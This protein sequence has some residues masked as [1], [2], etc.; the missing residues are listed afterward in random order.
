[1]VEAAGDH[2]IAMALAVAA[3]LAEGPTEL[4]GAEWIDVSYPGFLDELAALGRGAAAA[5]R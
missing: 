4:A 5:A 2:R 1:V 3:A